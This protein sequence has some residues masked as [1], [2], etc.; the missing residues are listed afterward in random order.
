MIF[1]ALAGILLLISLILSIIMWFI[2]GKNL[3]SW[4][5]IMSFLGMIFAFVAAYW[6]ADSGKK[7][8]VG[9]PSSPGL[10]ILVFLGSLI[11]AIYFLTAA[12]AVVFFRYMHFCRLLGWRAQQSTWNDRM[13]DS[14]SFEDGWWWNKWILWFIGFIAIVVGILFAYIA[15]AAWS[16]T[17]NRFRLGRYALYLACIFLIING[18]MM[19]YWGEEIFQW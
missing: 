9:N 17:Y 10:T 15:Y 13:I 11:F 16:I 4:H 19:I 14:L 8:A 18:W 7:I 1:G 3:I 6:A 2:D 5:V 12:L